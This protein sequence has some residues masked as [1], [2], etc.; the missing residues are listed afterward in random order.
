M[1]QS[2]V[3]RAATASRL[4]A[5]GY[6]VR[7]IAEEMGV[8]RTYA[9]DLLT[10]PDGSKDR[11]RK[12]RYSGTCDLC[13]G[14]TSPSNTSVPHRRCRRCQ[15][16]HPKNLYW[17]RE[18]I[19]EAIQ[20]FARENGGRRPVSTDW[21]G[22][23]NKV[24]VHG[25]AGS[26]Y[27]YVATVLTHF[28]SWAD[29]IEAAGFE[30]PVVGQYYAADRAEAARKRAS[31]RRNIVKTPQVWTMEKGV[32]LLKSVSPWGVAPPIKDP[33]IYNFYMWTQR[34]GIKWREVCEQAGV[35]ARSDRPYT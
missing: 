4:R 15:L 3:D 8:S 12:K 11:K 6:T 5:K 26:G 23:R 1:K 30:R 14:P 2:R 9:S 27:P 24:T 18:R 19:I 7:R 29:A 28:G 17:T 21:N 25:R 31:R 34:Q 22:G 20:R 32:S 33:R 13:G 16:A 10:D 35:R